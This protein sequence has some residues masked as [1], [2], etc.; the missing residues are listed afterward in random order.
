L[1][2]NKIIGGTLISIP[3]IALTLSASAEFSWIFAAQM[4]GGVGVFMGLV[5]LGTY[6]LELD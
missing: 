5:V 1:K 3:F 4:W 2:T 6:L